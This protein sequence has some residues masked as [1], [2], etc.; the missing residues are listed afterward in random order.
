MHDPVIVMVVGA[1]RGSVFTHFDKTSHVLCT[2]GPI[3]S[4]STS[5]M[6]ASIVMK[7]LVSPLVLAS[8]RASVTAGIPIKVWAVE[9]NPNAVVTL[10][11]MKHDLRWEDRVTIVASDMRE[12]GCNCCCGHCGS[13]W[14]AEMH[15]LSS[16]QCDIST[17]LAIFLVESTVQG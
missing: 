15:A 4:L 5:S 8:L 2:S 11:C 17:C 10:R 12:V 3:C 1:G 9:K 14:R 13:A 6:V 7:W 16:C